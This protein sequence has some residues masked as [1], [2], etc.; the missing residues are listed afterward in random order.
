[1][2]AS[3]IEDRMLTVELQLIDNFGNDGSAV[4][5]KL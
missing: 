4:K 1:M 2:S 3:M 5:A